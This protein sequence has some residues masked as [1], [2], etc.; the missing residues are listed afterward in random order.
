[1]SASSSERDPVRVGDAIREVVD[2]AGWRERLA[3]GRLRDGWASI[4]GTQIAAHSAPAR[5]GGGVLQ[6]RAEPG[7]WATELALLAAS[8]AAKSDAF[9]GGGLVQSV[10]VAARA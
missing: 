4:V 2:E 6:V 3:L 8:I 5:L 10:K 1:M 9:L 7:A